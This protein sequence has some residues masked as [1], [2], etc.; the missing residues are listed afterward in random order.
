MVTIN[1]VAKE[2][3]VA[4]S[5]VSN[6]INGKGNVSQKTKDKVQRV[7]DELGYQVDPV[8]RRMKNGRSKMVGM[9]ITDFSRIFFAPV[10]RRCREIASTMGYT[11][12]C[13]ETND[14]F[15]L[16]KQHISL[17]Q[18]NR[19]DA[20][21]LNTVADIDD[22]E[23]YQQLRA[24]SYRD[25]NI[26]VVCIERDLASHGLDSVETD[27]YSGAVK[28]TNHLISLG[29]RNIMHITGPVNSWPA[30]RRVRGFCETIEEHT[31]INQQ[32]VLG[33]FS[34]Y[35]GYN[36]VRNIVV[37]PNKLPFDAIFASNDQM[38]VGAMKALQEMNVEI[39]EQVCIVGYDDSF[40]A[41]LIEPS[42]TSV[43]VSGSN[44]GA[45]AI[46]MVLERIEGDAQPA[47]CG[48]IDTGL[49]VRRSTDNDIYVSKD[50]LNWW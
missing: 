31:D 33:D 26:P 16:E 49:V 27:N 20:I 32:I 42:L 30:E 41:S 1:D 8:A 6:I 17:M 11:L 24:L 5:T 2:A 14:D 36:A 15:K 25:K 35:S 22:T 10:I 46:R 37:N 19:F 21:I 48:Q 39:P 40:V 34:P 3:G 18:K 50:Y 7:I 47:R 29:C 43:H 9:I 4:I 38:A 23:Y 45:E 12:M 44:I 13:V 28:A